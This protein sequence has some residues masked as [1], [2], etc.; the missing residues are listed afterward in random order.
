[1]HQKYQFND[2]YI[3]K[4]SRWAGTYANDDYKHPYNK[5]TKIKPV[6][7]DF[8]E[9]V[10]YPI[11]INNTNKEEIDLYYPIPYFK[12]VNDS[13]VAVYGNYVEELF[14]LKKTGVLTSRNLFKATEEQEEDLVES[15]QPKSSNAPLSLDDMKF[16]KFWDEFTNSID[17]SNLMNF[18]K[19]A[20]DTLY[21]CDNIIATNQFI[22]KCFNEVF[23][24]EVKKRIIDKTKLESDYYDLDHSFKLLTSN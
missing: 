1:Y 18:K 3:T 19:I 24:S 17:E 2:V 21:V 4:D 10:A 8:A 6:K 15:M 20:L 7:I 11:S 16:F 22:E 23:D 12:I 13:A 14:E 9:K 5:R